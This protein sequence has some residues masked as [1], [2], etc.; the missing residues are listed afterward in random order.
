M[1]GYTNK[2]IQLLESLDF[3]LKNA[4]ALASQFGKFSRGFQ[5]LLSEYIGQP[6]LNAKDAQEYVRFIDVENQILKVLTYNEDI[7]SE[8]IL[9]QQ[10]RLAALEEIVR[11]RKEV[12]EL[13]RVNRVQA[14][15]ITNLE[16]L[17]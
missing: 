9:M 1:D 12:K 15:T 17:D 5:I 14:E 4:R 16:N 2:A 13:R 10:K 7:L 8:R 3:D 11:L 6:I